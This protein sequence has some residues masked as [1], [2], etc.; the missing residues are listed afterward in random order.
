MTAS[1][2]PALPVDP[3]AHPI[4]LFDGVCN[5]CNG[6]VRFLIDHDPM[7]R[8]RFAPLQSEVGRALQER[9]H[10]DPDTL[11][12]FVL[13]DG[14]GAHVRSDAVLGILCGL[15]SPWRWLRF[16]RVVPRPLRDALYRFVASRR[17]RWFGKRDECPVPTPEIRS[18]F[19]A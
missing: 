10:L 5:L 12:T 3:A 17:Y 7:A 13:V 9:H 1:P 18:R 11:D 14:D 16:L 4:V 8:F 19:L 6:T 15:P 2:A